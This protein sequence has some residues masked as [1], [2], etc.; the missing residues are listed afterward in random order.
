MDISNIKTTLKNQGKRTVIFAVISLIF[1]L[2][3]AFY[4]GILGFLSGSV[5]FLASFFYYLLLSI[6]RFWAVHQ[7]RK[8]NSRA[9]S[10]AIGI[11]L[12]IL[13]FVF[14]VVVFLSIRQNAPVKYG[15]IT[16]LTIATYTFTKII[17]ASVRAVKQRRNNNPLLKEIWAISYSEIAVSVLT[18]QRSMLV[19]FGQME[20][21]KSLILN[22]FTGVGVCVFIL[23]L[24]ILQLRRK[25]NGKI[26]NS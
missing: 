26:E 19:S 2:L 10:V 5:L 11:M 4:N 6:M 9:I 24:G 7:K 3:Y 25:C 18:M 1:N 17:T 22:V 8:N 13:C 21:E 15:E 23:F 20:Q 14:S 12:I 16:M